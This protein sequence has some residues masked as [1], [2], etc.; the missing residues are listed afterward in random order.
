MI[1][2]RKTRQFTIRAQITVGREEEEILRGIQ[3]FLDDDF[4][5][6]YTNKNDP[7]SGLPGA[8][9]MVIAT[10]PKLPEPV[11]IRIYGSFAGVSTVLNLVD[12]SRE[13]TMFHRY[14][15]MQD[16]ESLDLIRA[17]IDEMMG[18]DFAK[19]IS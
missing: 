11:H 17:W 1:A 6:S 3:M 10:H 8:T 2:N 9:P 5:V 14:F 7:N 16:P 15:N 18:D 12:F 4:K 13:T 19:E